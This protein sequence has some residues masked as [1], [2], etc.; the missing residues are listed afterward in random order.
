MKKRHNLVFFCYF[1][2]LLETN[3]IILLEFVLYMTIIL[4]SLSILCNLMHDYW[5]RHLECNP[6]E[7]NKEVGVHLTRP[8]NLQTFIYKNRTISH[9]L[10]QNGLT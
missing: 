8:I 10:T 1:F 6:Y 9:A 2:C 5:G 3:L 4:Y 7:H